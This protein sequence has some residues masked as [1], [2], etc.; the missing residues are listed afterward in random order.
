MDMISSSCTI[1]EDEAA[2]GGGWVTGEPVIKSAT[3]LRRCLE[4]LQDV[5]K[6][7]TK[8]CFFKFQQNLRSSFEDFAIHYESYINNF[9]PCFLPSFLSHLLANHKVS[10]SAGNSLSK[11]PTPSQPDQCP[12]QLAIH[13]TPSYTYEYKANPGFFWLSCCSV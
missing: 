3:C 1:P 5:F 6:N 10:N 2:R 7:P 11:P 12:I 9:W 4:P 8:C 13:T